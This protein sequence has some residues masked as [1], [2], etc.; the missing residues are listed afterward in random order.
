MKPYLI[1]F[2]NLKFEFLLGWR[3]VGVYVTGTPTSRDIVVTVSKF[4]SLLPPNVDA[5]IIVVVVTLIDTHDG[6]MILRR[7]PVTWDA[8]ALIWRVDINIYTICSTFLHIDHKS[9]IASSH[10]GVYVWQWQ[11]W[12]CGVGYEVTVLVLWKQRT[13]KPALW[14]LMGTLITKDMETILNTDVVGIVN[15]IFNRQFNLA[16]K[17]KLYIIRA[18]NQCLAGTFAF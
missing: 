13:N 11:E 14:V 4:I 6:V 1:P 15:R 9:F 8:L 10:A 2:S 7:P 5:K 3:G 12:W 17:L 16:P 18:D